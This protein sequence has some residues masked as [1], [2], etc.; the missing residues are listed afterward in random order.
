MSDARRAR[1]EARARVRMRPFAREV[2]G[3]PVSA[4]AAV[5]NYTWDSAAG[6]SMLGSMLAAMQWNAPVGHILGCDLDG[7]R[8]EKGRRSAGRSSCHIARVMCDR[9]RPVKLAAARMRQKRTSSR[10]VD[11]SADGRLKPTRYGVAKG[12]LQG[13]SPHLCTAEPNV[14]GCG[15]ERRSQRHAWTSSAATDRR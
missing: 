3:E 2:Q 15:L 7:A 12:V 8:G 1:R 4:M 9:Q 11:C 14:I 6:L 10:A 5:A 13:K